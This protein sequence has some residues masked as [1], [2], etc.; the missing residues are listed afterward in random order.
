MNEQ[1]EAIHRFWFGELPPSGLPDPGLR[2]RWFA[3]G[4]AFDR[5]CAR[6]FG[7]LLDQA[8]V[9]GL[10]DWLDDP[11]GALALVLLLDQIPRNVC[12]GTA[13]AFSGDLRA[14]EI[15]TRSVDA[16]KDAALQPV[17]R[18]FL[19]MPFEHA[20]DPRAQARSVALFQK[21]ADAAL[22][23][24]GDLFANAL[25]WAERHA[26]VIDRFGRF[27][28]RNQALGRETTAE[29]SAYLAEHPAGF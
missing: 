24:D 10:A 11:R 22:P 27:P 12:R 15:A 20:E 16:G 8:L 3:G 25:R 19:Y 2:R 17:E 7:P 9:G 26:A 13:R 5:E 6:A 18:Y 29:E 23:A 28:G 4:D 1:V 21:L 14:L